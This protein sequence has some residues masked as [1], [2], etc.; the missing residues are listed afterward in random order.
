MDSIPNVN[1]MIILNVEKPLIY[2]SSCY[3]GGIG[4][5]ILITIYEYVCVFAPK[6]ENPKTS[7]KRL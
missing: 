3:S 6:I 1:A 5:L 2:I 4:R 7:G